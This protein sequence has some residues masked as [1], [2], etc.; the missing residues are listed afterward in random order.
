MLRFILF[1][2]LAVAAWLLVKKLLAAAQSD[3][4]AQPKPADVQAMKR[5]A[6]CGV[7]LPEA[8]ALEK[9]GRHFCCADHRDQFHA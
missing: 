4:E 7:Y 5:C 8:D 3:D 6:Q 1:A 2:A 9:D